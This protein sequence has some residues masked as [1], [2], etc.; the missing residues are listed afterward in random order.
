MRCLL[1]GPLILGLYR[2]AAATVRLPEEFNIEKDWDEKEKWLKAKPYVRCDLCRLLVGNT[3]DTIGEQFQED[4]IYDHIDKICD[5]KELYD[6]HE[7]WENNAIEP[8]NSLLPKW[9]LFP[10]MTE[11]TAH[12]QRWQSHAMQELCDN[13]IL[14]VDDE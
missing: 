7:L 5:A 6:K 9:M 12:T 2:L 14:P 1:V 10:T 11:R 8:P 3:F 13:V 4:D